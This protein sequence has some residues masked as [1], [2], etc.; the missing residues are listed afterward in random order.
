MTRSA[1]DAW[2]IR[3]QDRSDRIACPGGLSVYRVRIY[4]KRLAGFTLFYFSDT[5]IRTRPVRSLP[6]P[7]LTWRGTAWIEKNLQEACE[8][9][10]PDAIIFGGDL[11]SESVWLDDAF[12]M[13]GRLPRNSFKAAVPGN[14]DMRRCEWIPD[15]VWEEGYASAGFHFLRNRSARCGELEFY[16]ADDLKTGV[17]HPGTKRRETRDDTLFRCFL[18]HNPDTLPFCLTEQ[19]LQQTRLILCGHTHGGQWRIPCFGAWKTS[20]FFRKKFELGGYCRESSGTQLFVSGGIGATWM[21][22]RLFCP[23]EA[24]LFEFTGDPE[25]NGETAS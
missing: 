21:P 16:G 4:E 5:H 17:P 9:K 19:D 24:W 7:P 11:V 13:L 1:A 2:K 18:A 6:F 8:F 22:L 10:H 20:S 25:S 23:P 14:W 15:R 12:A 3:K